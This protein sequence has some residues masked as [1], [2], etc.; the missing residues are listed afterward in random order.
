MDIISLGNCVLTYLNNNI[1][2]MGL[3]ENRDMA[4][5]YPQN[6]IVTLQFGFAS[7][8]DSW[9]HNIYVILQHSFLSDILF[10]C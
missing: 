4:H 3:N 8:G 10:L 6:R 5:H 7:F 2:Y 1:L 9:I